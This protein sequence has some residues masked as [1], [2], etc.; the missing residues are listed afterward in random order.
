MGKTVLIGSDDDGRR[1]DRILRKY[2]PGMP[3]SALHRLL[4]KG[5]VRIDGRKAEGADRVAAGSEL[6]LPDLVELPSTRAVEKAPREASALPPPRIIF[7]NEHLLIADKEAGIL[8]HGID[9]LEQSVRSYLSGKLPPSLS[10][11][12]GPLH[13]L[14]R[15]TSGL[16]AFSKSIEGARRFSAAMAERR[17]G[18]RYL[19]VLDGA[20]AVPERWEDRLERDALG[21]K[22]SVS[23][24][25][26]GK[27]AFTEAAPLAADEETTLALITLGTGLTHQIRVQAAS[28]GH[29][30]SGDRKYG[31]SPV[32]GG[33][34]LH[35][36]ELSVDPDTM[37]AGFL[38]PV[39]NAP[40]PDRFLKLIRRR[41][42]PLLA[43]SL[44][45]GL[46]SARLLD[47]II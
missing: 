19:A 11:T 22:S 35:A 3:L 25:A 17:I 13:R 32:P 1:L 28:R 46:P 5:T 41:F 30:L 26:C 9:S 23:P 16:I 29:P 31:G 44:A 27:R 15:G 21:M 6:T 37:G 20:L 47:A 24:D 38:P 39:L 14:D 34:F 40:P 18:K 2:L 42:G 12:P 43:D 33:F 10:F 45:Q 4:R 8:T 7:E 36:Y